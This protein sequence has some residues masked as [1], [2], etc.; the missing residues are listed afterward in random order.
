MCS[1]SC[2]NCLLFAT[3][4]VT[5][6]H[7]GTAVARSDTGLSGDWGGLRTKLTDKGIDVQA[8]YQSNTAWNPGGGKN[9]GARYAD[10]WLLAASF[11]LGKLAN[12]DGATFYIGLTRRDGRSLTKDAIGNE[13]PAQEIY[14]DGQDFRLTDLWYQQTFDEGH[15]EVRLG[16]VHSAD[17]FAHFD[18]TFQ[19]LGFCGSPYA[20]LADS[21]FSQFPLGVWGARI[22]F[23]SG[24]WYAETGAYQV[25]PTYTNS[26]NG[27]KLNLSGTT[28]VLLPAE[29]GVLPKL[30]AQSLPGDYKIGAYY[31]SSDT[32]DVY[33]DVHD[34][35]AALTGLP[36]RERNGRY[37]GYVM[38]Q[39][40]VTAHTEGSK[41]GLSVFADVTLADRNTAPIRDSLTLGIKYK[42]PF[43]SR[44]HDQA[45]FA[46]GRYKFNS[47]LAAYQRQLDIRGAGQV[48]VQDAETDIALQYNAQVARYCT[49]GPNLQYVV[50]PNGLRSIDN[51]FVIGLQAKVAF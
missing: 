27:F 30:G 29:V 6:G 45:E 1:S 51:A 24:P 47:R 5:F 3:A 36:L 8:K 31:D 49:L 9:R 21:G 39:Q 4:L 14:G 16:R 44:P 43:A 28:G 18:C 17:D 38:A 35:P 42:G 10:Q 22:K 40:Q 46:V 19:N 20:I 11:D 25:N 48:G 12:I 32:P 26:S 33:L 13:V 2:K 23:M 15:W 34:Q 50:H 41:Q 7:L 37:G